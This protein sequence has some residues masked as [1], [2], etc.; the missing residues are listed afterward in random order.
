MPSHQIGAALDLAIDPLDRVGAVELD[1]MLPG[2][3][4][5]GQH[6]CLGLVHDRS[7]L[8]HFGRIWSAT[9][10]HWLLAAPGVS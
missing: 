5:I 3:S 10:R 1:A 7:E 6:V 9:A 2:E 8:G 4:R